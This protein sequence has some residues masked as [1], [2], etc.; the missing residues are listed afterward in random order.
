MK[1]HGSFPRVVF[2]GLTPAAVRKRSEVANDIVFELYQQ[3]K[4]IY[5]SPEEMLHDLR[6]MRNSSEQSE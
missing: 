2:V 5:Q 4:H 6:Q 3:F 1:R